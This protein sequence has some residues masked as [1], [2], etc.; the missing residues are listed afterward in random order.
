MKKAK[1]TRSLMAACSIVALSAVMYG[2]VHS[3]DD[4]PPPV[5]EPDPDPVDVDRKA[6]NDAIDAAETAISGLTAMSSDED[7]AAAQALIDAAQTALDGTTVLPVTEVRTLQGEIDA[8]QT[9]LDTAET[10]IANYRT[11]Q[12]QHS[13]AMDAV[14]AA[15]TAVDGLTAMSS[16]A[17]VM[18]ADNAIAAAKQAVAAG[19]MLTDDEKATLN[20][21]IEVAELSLTNKKTQIADRKAQEEEDRQRTAATNAVNAAVMAV[22]GLTNMSSDEDVMAAQ[23]LID[24]ARTAVSETTALPASEVLALQG[25]IS[26]AQ[27]AHDT[28]EMNISNY[29]THQSQFSDAND[30]VDAAR[31]AVAGLTAMS[32]DADVE[33]AETAIADAKMAV[34]DGTMLTPAEVAS[35]N[36]MISSAETS[37][38]TKKT[39]ISNYRTHGNQYTAAMDAVNDAT[40]AVAGLTD[41]SSDADVEAAKTA[42]SAAEM[43]VEAGTLLTDDELADLNGKIAIV[44]LSLQ[45]AETN[46][47]NHR[48]RVGQMTAANTA[49]DEAEKAVAALDINSSDEA[50]TDAQTKIAAAKTAV[51]DGTMLTQSEKDDLNGKITVAETTLEGVEEQIAIR[52]SGEVAQQI[53]GW[54][55]DASDATKKAT[56]AGTAADDA[57]EE[58][59]DY[60][61]KL[62][63]ASV[64]GD[65]SVAKANAEKVLQADADVD[66]A[67]MNAEAAKADAEAAKTAAEAIPDG[68]DGKTEVIAALNEA[69][70]AAE[71]QIAAT[72]AI[73][74]GKNADDSVN[75]DGVKL[76][77]AV[78]RVTGD[79]EDDVKTPTD[80]GEEVAMAVGGALLPTVPDTVADATTHDGTARRVE[81]YATPTALSG[82]TGLPAVED[83]TFHDNDSSGMTWAEIVGAANIV[84]ERVGTD[85]AVR[86]LAP[87]SGT[88][89]DIDTDLTNTGGTAGDGVYADGF[90][91]AASTY[92]GIP[93]D[94]F[95]LGGTAGCSVDADGN[96]MGGWYF[97]PTSTSAV[98]LAA[99]APATGYVE[100]TGFAQWGHWL[101]VDSTTGDVTVH[102]YATTGA[103]IGDLN[104]GVSTAT[105]QD[106]TATYTGSAAGMS[107]HKTFDSDGEQTSINSGAF[108]ATA[109]LTARFG[110]APM[111]KGTIS[112]FEG[113]AHIDSGWSVE[114][115][116]TAL[117]ATAGFD[118]VGV[119]KG[120]GQA[121]DWSTQGYGPTPVDGANQRPTGFFGNFE[122]HFTDGHASGAYVTRK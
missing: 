74:T 120:S 67:V 103:N 52:K 29:R 2:C 79:D 92:M 46:I 25:R 111:L 114:L 14:G 58:A 1:L 71:A 5:V 106:E 35:L 54:H 27:T 82:A 44:K 42:I 48:I 8:A 97:S 21:A 104:I 55:E 100:D 12:S 118:A 70:K 69:I 26:A 121:G 96:L 77:T 39:Q 76:R 34:V 80:K 110:T 63:V 31:M 24:A 87:I 9:A 33:A 65:S 93:G 23:G 112:G 22:A 72:K 81:H 73:D 59:D 18:A 60:S 49:V 28:A 19:T 116:E 94:V 4:T 85:N 66:Q 43:A 88:A 90:T 13:A 119:A 56:A 75:A 64:K 51:M 108:T 37:L 20:G 113:G 122:A 109:S 45:T 38:G 3:G 32:S 101:A 68:T 36:G 98:Y 61:M 47:A 117:N 17:D 95:C 53:V 57:V 99:T 11:H 84:M 30:A 62:D 15:E 107:V 115:Q 89:A 16:D 50:V 83:R 91:T 41:M 78:Q 40:T 10:N 102:T 6:I 105:G 86:S 7:V